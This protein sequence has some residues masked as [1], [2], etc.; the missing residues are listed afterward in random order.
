MSRTETILAPRTVP[1]YPETADEAKCMIDKLYD[2]KR[3][4]M[5]TAKA[6]Y[7]E[8]VI[9]QGLLVAERKKH[10]PRA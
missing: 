2:D 7:D 9:A 10:V 1:I 5:L 6:L 3:Q 4:W 8:L